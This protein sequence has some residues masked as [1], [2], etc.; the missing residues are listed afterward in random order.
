MRLRS[1]VLLVAAL[2]GAALGAAAQGALEVIPLRHRTAEQVLP[3]LRPLLEP[4]AVLTGQGSQLIVRTSERNLAELRRALQAIDTPQRRLVILVRFD[5]A[6][7][8]ASSAL[9]TRGSVSTDRSRVVIRATGESGALEERVD[10]RIQVLE[11]AR[12]FISTAETRPLQEG[13]VVRTPG[14]TIASR[15]TVIQ[16]ASSGFEVVP[17]LSG[18]TVMLD[19]APQRETFAPAGS[20]LPPGSVQGQRL[21]TTVSGPLGEWIDL[22]GTA[23]AGTQDERGVL[24]ARSA[25]SSGERRIWVKVE[26]LRP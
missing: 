22:G 8:S 5:S 4:G 23:G 6:G 17:R 26:E 12:A 19:I 24:S 16:E 20:G 14:G 7:A 2:S 25:R 1:K 3:A 11:G 18:S 13:T 15:T 9:E 21:A 10:Q